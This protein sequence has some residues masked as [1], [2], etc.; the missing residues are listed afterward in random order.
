MDERVPEEG[1]QTDGGAP[2]RPRR[3]G[4]SG[5]AL[6]ALIIGTL[7]GLAWLIGGAVARPVRETCDP[8][9]SPA[10]CTETVTAALKKGMPRQHPLILGAHAEP[11]PA[12]RPDQLGHRATVTFDLLGVPGPTTVRLY[13]DM[14]GHWGGVPDRSAAELALWS[15][16]QAVLVAAAAGCGVWWL[17]RRRRR[18]VPTPT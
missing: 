9:L 13:T 15:A 7:L 3:P 4:R 8:A 10:A 12:S 5:R 14:G 6:W 2:P 18:R 16:A 17:S 11:G 1:D